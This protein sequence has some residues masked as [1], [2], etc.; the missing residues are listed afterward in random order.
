MF[1]KQQ[2]KIEDVANKM[3]KEM[4]TDLGS[5]LD[6]QKKY[7]DFWQ[8]FASIVASTKYVDEHKGIVYT[9]NVVCRANSSTKA[10][11]IQRLAK[12][13]EICSD[14][15][16]NECQNNNGKR[17]EVTITFKKPVNAYVMGFVVVYV[18]DEYK[19]NNRR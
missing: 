14:A 5:L 17:F 19:K 4:E 15:K 1:I 16:I 2:G 18:N 13:L 11:K 8:H 7:I 3:A 10:Q 9:D 12:S 6:K